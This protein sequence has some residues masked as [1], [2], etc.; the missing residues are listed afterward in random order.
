MDFFLNQEI[1]SGK[2]SSVDGFSQRSKAI[3]SGFQL[4]QT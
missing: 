3:I 2:N 1:E 4:C